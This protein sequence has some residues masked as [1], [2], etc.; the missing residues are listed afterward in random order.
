MGL[1]YK[2]YSLL[3]AGLSV[4][5]VAI[6][7]SPNSLTGNAIFEPEVPLNC[8]EIN[9][10]ELWNSIFEEQIQEQTTGP[11]PP[12]TGIRPTE[13]TFQT[14]ESPEGKCD[15]FVAYYAKDSSPQNKELWL[16]RGWNNVDIFDPEIQIT[17][18]QGIVTGNYFSTQI[19]GETLN[20]LMYKDFSYNTLFSKTIDRLTSL[21]S[22]SLTIDQF[23]DTIFKTKPTSLADWTTIWQFL[24]GYYSSFNYE[25]STTEQESITGEISSRKDL[26]ILTYSSSFCIP[27]WVEKTTDCEED[28]TETIYFVDSMGCGFSPVAN[29]TTGC[30]YDENN[31]IGF[32]LDIEETGLDIELEIDGDEFDETGAT[33]YEDEL[34][35]EIKDGTKKLIEFEWD[36][37]EPLNLKQIF[38]EKQSSSSTYGYLIVKGIKADKTLYVDKINPSINNICVN[39]DDELDSLSDISTTC[40]GSNE[41]YL[42]CSGSISDIDCYLSNSTLVVS[43]VDHSAVK[44]MQR[45]TTTCTPNWNCT[46]WSDSINQCGIRTCTDIKCGSN[47][48]T[49]TQT[50]FIDISCTP[51]WDCTEWEPPQCP[52]SGERTR[53]CIDAE[54]CEPDKTETKKCSY[55]ID[56]V[57]WAFG[58]II[59]LVI[60]VVLAIFGL[61][62]HYYRKKKEGNNSITQNITPKYPPVPPRK[63]SQGPSYGFQQ[64]PRELR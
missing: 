3:V 20:N 16:I 57:N 12:A 63:F 36:F 55:A 37:S 23:Y 34:D 46:D 32:V 33:V 60:L 52:E 21:G 59:F 38:L 31:V 30:D 2:K 35:V 19:D 62:I 26:Q 64:R 18:I 4:I 14:L 44:Q 47:P 51:D 49:E 8:S 39:E 43:G 25:E 22:N 53:T 61:I 28:E 45:T 40:S 56:K 11:S 42:A 17:A 15:M 6:I 50:C 58:L 41:F 54:A 7:L 27:N 10:I 29:Q 48:K 13:V 24:K 9:I 5:L 1:D